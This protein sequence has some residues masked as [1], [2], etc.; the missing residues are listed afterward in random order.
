MLVG[1][2]RKDDLFPVRHGITREER[3]GVELH[4]AIIR[5]L[6]DGRTIRPLDY[7]PELMLMVGLG[8]LGGFIR[9]ETFYW[10]ALFRAGLF[11][12]TFLLYFVIVSYVFHAYL[13]IVNTI[14]H[15]L[16]FSLSYWT[17]ATVKRRWFA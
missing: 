15:L 17:V 11:W 4:S 5:S 6:L 16:V 14:Y 9:I 3:Y 8:L 7:W 12:T 13:V 2:E 10:Q 1:I